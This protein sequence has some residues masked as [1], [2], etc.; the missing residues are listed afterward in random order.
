MVT[1][2]GYGFDTSTR[3]TYK[4]AFIS[5]LN[6]SRVSATAVSSTQV[7]CTIPCWGCSIPASGSVLITLEK[8]GENR[9]IYTSGGY[10][11]VSNSPKISLLASWSEVR[12]RVG[13]AA[14]GESITVYG[15][16]LSSLIVYICQFSAQGHS[17][18]S[19]APAVVK[20]TESMECTT[21]RFPYGTQFA[22]VSIVGLPFI[23]GGDAS[24]ANYLFVSS[25]FRK[26][27]HAGPLRGG[28]VVVVHGGGFMASAGYVNSVLCDVW[29]IVF[30][31]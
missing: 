21:P 8:D 23:E 13:P 19:T 24:L 10:K 5:S 20:T 15:K 18:N 9:V 28:T 31:C 3:S 2:Q 11:D 26:S 22:G 17:V 7:V 29:L 27:I 12:P 1:I 4:C 25:W 30:V 14:G 6:A 16:G